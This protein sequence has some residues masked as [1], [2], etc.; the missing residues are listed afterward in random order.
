M[1][2]NVPADK[3]ARERFNGS[4]QNKINWINSRREKNIHERRDVN[5]PSIERSCHNSNGFV[6]ERIYSVCSG[7]ISEAIYK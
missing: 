4:I 1:T 2:S 7:K 3:Y 5:L 6:G